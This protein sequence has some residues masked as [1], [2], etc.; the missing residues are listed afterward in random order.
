MKI[1]IWQKSLISLGIVGGGFGGAIGAIYS[2]SKTPKG[3]GTTHFTQKSLENNLN[4]F[5]DI[6]KY[7]SFFVDSITNE[8]IGTYNHVKNTVDGEQ[9]QNW[10]YSYEIKNKKTPVQIVQGGPIEFR[11]YYPAAIFPKTFVD[12]VKWF[13]EEIS[14]GAEIS[15]LSYFKIS[16]G[17]RKS[18]V[19][20]VTLGNYGVVEGK[21][22]IELSPDS[23]YGETKIDSFLIKML[24]ED[25]TKDQIPILIKSIN[26][27]NKAMREKYND[28][29]WRDHVVRLYSLQKIGENKYRPIVSKVADMI[30]KIERQSP[31]ELEKVSDVDVIW[32]EKAMTVKTVNR[33]SY[34]FNIG[35]SISN[36]QIWKSLFGTNWK[37]LSYNWLKYTTQHEY[38]HMLTL[39]VTES[40][41]NKYVGL[42]VAGNQP[43]S[44]SGVADFDELNRY[45]E[46]RVPQIRALRVSVNLNNVNGKY[47]WNFYKD[48]LNDYSVGISKV[49]PDPRDFDQ[50]AF[51][52][53]SDGQSVWTR[54]SLEKIFGNTINPFDPQKA[55]YRVDVDEFLAKLKA[56]KRPRFFNYSFRDAKEFSRVTNIPTYALYIMN[57]FDA[58]PATKNPGLTSKLGIWIGYSR[59]WIL[60]KEDKVGRLKY[61]N[62]N[63]EFKRVEDILTEIEDYYGNNVLV[64]VT[65]D[66]G[67][68]TLKNYQFK[69]DYNVLVEG[70]IVSKTKIY[71]ISS[72]AKEKDGNPL[73]NKFQQVKD[74]IN[75]IINKS[76][77]NTIRGSEYISYLISKI[78]VTDKFKYEVDVTKYLK[79][80]DYTLSEKKMIGKESFARWTRHDDTG[81]YY[82]SFDLNNSPEL[83]TLTDHIKN[84]TVGN[85]MPRSNMSNESG[86]LSASITKL[87]IYNEFTR[88]IEEITESDLKKMNFHIQ[89]S[90]SKKSQIIYLVAGKEFISWNKHNPLS[91]VTKL[92]INFSR[93]GYSR[94]PIDA[95]E[96]LLPM[97]KNVLKKWLDSLS[98]GYA[99]NINREFASYQYSFEEVLTR[100]WVQITKKLQK[101][102]NFNYDSNLFPISGRF[103]F[104]T[105][106][107]LSKLFDAIYNKQ[108]KK[109]Y[110]DIINPFTKYSSKKRN[111]DYTREFIKIMYDN[112][113]N[114]ENKETKEL[115][116]AFVPRIKL[117]L[118]EDVETYSRSLSF[119]NVESAETLGINI[120]LDENSKFERFYSSF[121]KT[122]K[123]DKDS[124]TNSEISNNGYFRDRWL[125]SSLASNQAEEGTE[126]SWVLYDDRGVPIPY[127][128]SFKK[129]D[130]TPVTT[131]PEAFWTFLLKSHGVG[132]RNISSIW[133]SPERDAVAMWGYMP[134]TY[135]NKIKYIQFKNVNNTNVIKI[136]IR[137]NVDNLFYYSKKPGG[138]R[139]TTLD[140]EGFVSWNIDYTIMGT[141]V[142]AKLQNGNYEINFVDKNGKIVNI[143]WNN[144][145]ISMTGNGK[146]VSNKG[147]KKITDH[148]ITI[149]WQDE[150][151][152]SIIIKQN[153]QGKDI[154]SIKNQFSI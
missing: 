51:E 59:H 149:N 136:P 128:G 105:F 110:R 71:E 46:A 30:N 123:D 145:K 84:F 97:K 13:S 133:L 116:K 152:A 31:I 103:G 4:D 8:K 92:K 53:R 44:I 132:I 38:G 111:Y 91:S 140:D 19:R 139:K 15:S 3:K 55:P 35:K 47:D 58:L 24:H 81:Q 119:L 70:K 73:R 104:T 82:F 90:F 6:R 64:D 114:K 10:L 147:T 72:T 118:Y 125:R 150:I 57:A 74:L 107:E 80:I 62:N 124:W 7:K 21:K 16:K 106:L 56:G 122:T 66:V 9:V 89:L 153:N 100:D 83:K 54:E 68:R 40:T 87:E 99:S 148:I 134:K 5:K 50:I 96:A 146:L 88:K 135:Q 12:F 36:I 33:D 29:V 22:R 1:K 2:Y 23:F 75:K 39:S 42:K 117:T 93:V 67:K 14:W 127:K 94:P 131:R 101:T 109:T 26:D 65:T 61:L 143:I 141:W 121:F 63:G 76:N 78:G 154:I 41:A 32:N 49:K 17:I 20:S 113:L 130:G 151:Y 37:G 77:H 102:A 25:I 144:K 115:A 60:D 43:N 28:D 126:N 18:G 137:F 52:Y 120:F 98:E 34:K 142:D 27:T 48:R 69:F 129:I 86:G 79:K 85:M 108:T 138:G 11:N 112:L 45:F 95:K